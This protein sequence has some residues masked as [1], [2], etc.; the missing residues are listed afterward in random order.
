MPQ[1]KMPDGQVV[2]MPDEITPELATRLKA[3]QASAVTPSV[4]EN[5]LEVKKPEPSLLQS[6][7]DKYRQAG[8]VLQAG[9]QVAADLF[10][11][12]TEPIAQQ[13]TGMVAKPAGEIAGTMAAGLGYAGLVKPNSPI[14]DPAQVQQQVTQA[15]TYQPTQEHS[16]W[17]PLVG[18]PA[19]IGAGLEHIRPNEAQ[20]PSSVSGMAQ[21]AVREAIPQAMNF[22]GVKLGEKA[23]TAQAAKQAELDALKV[24]NMPRDT[25]REYFNKPD[26]QGLQFITPAEKGVEAAMSKMNTETSNAISVKNEG[27]ATQ[28][29]VNQLG[30]GKDEPFTIANIE[31]KKAEAGKA[32]DALVQSIENKAPSYTTDST[33]MGSKILPK[34]EMTD[35]VSKDIDAEISKLQAKAYPDGKPDPLYA[36]T[37]DTSIA[38]L[39]NEKSKAFQDPKTA[40]S[41][42]SDLRREAYKTL[43]SHDVAPRDAAQA[44]AKLFIAD[45]L[46]DLFE[47]NIKKVEGE[48]SPTFK[49]FIE[50]RKQLARLRVVENSMTESG[51]INMK[52]IG[53]IYKDNPAVLDGALK[54][55]GVFANE[56][57]Q[58]A[59]TVNRPVVGFSYFDTILATASLA[60][61]HPEGVALVGS[62]FLTPAYAKLGKL[63]SRTQS[64]VAGASP[65]TA[66]AF[67]VNPIAGIHSIMGVKTPSLRMEKLQNKLAT[68]NQPITP[69]VKQEIIKASNNDFTDAMKAAQDAGVARGKNMVSD[70]VFRRLVKEASQAAEAKS[71][72]EAGVARG[73]NLVNNSQAVTHAKLVAKQTEEELLKQAGVARGENLVAEAERKRRKQER[74]K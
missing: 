37:L 42:I 25:L 11:P 66:A 8:Q 22:L 28:K 55:V 21:N 52:M 4:T 67:A 71:L 61:G 72:M 45:K 18:I 32:Y 7:M 2:E 13:V 46:E 24:K 69:Q 54:D 51:T 59:K 57:S 9:G 43:S 14:S 68:D 26:A 63:Q 30:F 1:V 19:A 39:K 15:G 50:A 20:D 73:E 53:K 74:A 35:S 38:A 27:I 49:N 16:N 62:K 56:F 31:K 12:V 60:A 10:K 40:L 47:Q 70:D 65:L 5:K 34:L 64:Y 29:I 17:N 58:G 41:K 23:G 36:K 48:N 33:T 6:L 3:L 44:S